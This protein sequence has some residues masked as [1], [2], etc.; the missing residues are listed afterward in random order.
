MSVRLFVGNLA[1]DVTEDELRQ[2]F[3]AAGSPS[4]VRIPTDRETG[5]P[6]GF[7]F[8]EFAERQEAEEAIRQLHQQIFK[9]RPLAVNEARP[10]EER[11]MGAPRES[12]RPPSYTDFSM[13]PDQGAAHREAKRSFG[14]DAPR[15]GKK[16]P[17]KTAT[18]QQE[19]APKG[20]SK[21]KVD[22]SF[23]LAEDDDELDD[24][25]RWKKEDTS[26]TDE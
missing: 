21:P 6:R 12:V 18:R 22:R 19:R 7:A 25:S 24:F 5:K 2:L 15:G 17:E 8:V 20:Y 16:R 9:G 26:D 23:R 1:Y 13:P 4:L 3:S 10:R 14:P 11:P